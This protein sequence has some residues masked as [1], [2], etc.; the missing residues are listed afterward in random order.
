MNEFSNIGIHYIMNNGN[1]TRLLIEK[2]E[3]IKKIISNYIF[4][5]NLTF[6]TRYMLHYQ[7]TNYKIKSTI[8]S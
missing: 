5:S 6:Y 1:I 4:V 7:L 3:I 8:N 2:S